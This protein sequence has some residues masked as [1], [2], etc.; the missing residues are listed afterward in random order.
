MHAPNSVNNVGES[1]KYVI[2]PKGGMTIPSGGEKPT[3]GRWS[4]IDP[5]VFK[6][7]SETFL[8]HEK[9]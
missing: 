7:R 3:P 9:L 6:L 1:E 2:R 8:R 5:S 4:R